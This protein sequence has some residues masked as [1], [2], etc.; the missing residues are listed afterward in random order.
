[1]AV[2]L[3]LV[4]FTPLQAQPVSADG[5]S[6][7]IAFSQ[8]EFSSVREGYVSLS[9][10]ALDRAVE[11]VVSDSDGDIPYRGAFTQAFVSGLS[12]GE[13]RYT[14]AAFDE[15]GRQI[16][17][18]RLPAKVVV[19]HWPLWQALMLFGIG[20]FVFLI[21]IALILRGSLADRAEIRR[22][23]SESGELRS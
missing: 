12:D 17:T 16:A 11:Y 1:M 15:S 10:N 8:T 22:V 2:S 20:L 5:P 13:Y 23:L 18:S 14:V 9:W 7:E 4:L 21:I 3:V 19:E 6:D